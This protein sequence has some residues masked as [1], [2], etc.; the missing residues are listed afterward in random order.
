MKNTLFILITRLIQIFVSLISIRIMTELLPQ[1]SMGLFYIFN[2]LYLLVSLGVINP[3]GQFIN[4]ETNNY[5]K[6]GNICSLL[7]KYSTFTF[8][9]SILYFCVLLILIEFNIVNYNIYFIV[10]VFIY[11]IGLNL[12]QIYIYTLNIL[13]KKFLFSFLLLL[14]AVLSLS[15]SVLFINL[16]HNL[17]ER[18][19]LWLLGIC[20]SNIISVIIG[21]T[22]IRFNFGGSEKIE[23][24]FNKKEIK[25]IAIFAI[26]I[27][28]A[29]LF[30]WFSNTGYRF[31]IEHQQGLSYLGSFGVAF[32]IS[33]Q[34]MTVSESLCTQIFQPKLFKKIDSTELSII[35]YNISMY[36]R[37]LV[38]IYFLIAVFC[39]FFIKYIFIV[40]VDVK[41]LDYYQIGLVAIWFDFFRVLTNT[42][43][44]YFF[45]MRETK[46]LKYSYMVS[47]FIII[48]GLYAS[49]IFN[50]DNN[51]LVI[52]V[53]ILF[54]SIVSFMVMFT[55]YLRSSKLTFDVFFI[56]KRLLFFIPVLTIIAFNYNVNELNLKSVFFIF[57]ISLSFLISLFLTMK[58]IRGYQV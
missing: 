39:S 19:Y 21:F 46:K 43:S 25:S 4:R 8:V 53:V 44:M 40:L 32:G 30:M 5:H 18:L 50:Y 7:A 56:I 24:K 35:K 13:N 45:S 22:I 55:L 17:T 58:F 15:L 48:F 47:S 54:S 12:N 42:F 28:I 36:I 38:S 23:I 27:S 3:V 29:T 14:T 51:Q 57:I 31:I 20:L 2:S 9:I 16:F 33:S 6:N 34:I 10:L 52:P 37:E 1:K 26:P 11:I 49:H 41:Y